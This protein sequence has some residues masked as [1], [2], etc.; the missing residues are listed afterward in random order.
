MGMV[1][2]KPRRTGLSLEVFV[3][4]STTASQHL[5][6]PSLIVRDRQGNTNAA[7]AFDSPIEVLMGTPITGNAWQSLLRYVQLNQELLTA[8]WN[9]EIDQLTYVQRQKSIRGTRRE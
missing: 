2:L 4:E 1:A 7:V 5:R 6:R 3:S 8:L 9:E